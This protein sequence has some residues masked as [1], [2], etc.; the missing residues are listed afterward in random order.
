MA[1]V[2]VKTKYQLTLPTSVRKQ[3]RVAVG[4]LLEAKVEG[5][6]ITLTRKNLIDREL[7]LALHDVKRGRLSPT[8]VTPAEGIRWLSAEVKKRRSKKRVKKMA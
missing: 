5:N 1:L 6:K 7:A 8:F 4:D 3:A 2:T